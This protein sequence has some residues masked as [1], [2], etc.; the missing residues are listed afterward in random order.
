MKNRNIF[1][2]LILLLGLVLAACAEVPAAKQT[3]LPGLPADLQAS[4]SPAP[5]A[6]ATIEWFPATPTEPL[7]PTLEP[8]ATPERLAGV[9]P[10]IFADHFDEAN[11]WSYLTIKS[12]SP[13]KILLA[14]K[15]L[16]LAS[17]TPP[18]YLFSL[19]KDLSLVNFYATLQVSVNRCQADDQYGLLFRSAGDY[20]TYRYVLTCDGRLR[21]D[22]QRGGELSPLT[23]WTPSGDAPPGAPAQITL[24]IWAAG[25]EYRFFING[26]Y[27]FRIVDPLFRTG[28]LGVF[29]SAASPAGMNVSFSDLNIFSVSY[30]SPTP[31]LTPSETPTA[32]RTPNPTP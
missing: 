13:N 10:Q 21:I 16:T 19:R 30:V 32:S 15:R 23:E 9:G 29:T 20:Y 26:R 17:N 2:A 8:S 11:T 18:V 5:T 31:T 12:D 6:S 7:F 14:E 3:P 24:G 25:T 22:R 4:P 27:Q 28:T 1:P